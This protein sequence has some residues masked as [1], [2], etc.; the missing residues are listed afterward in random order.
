MRLEAGSTLILDE[1]GELK[2]N[3]RNGLPSRDSSAK[4][5][6]AWQSRIAYLWEGGYLGGP[7]RSASLASFHL[8]RVFEPALASDE[9]ESSVRRE[10]EE[11]R[12]K[13]A[14]R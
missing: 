3:I 2:F 7:D 10:T 1:Y 4:A 8:R 9:K 14:W 6:R 11:R 5:R 12:A 13:E